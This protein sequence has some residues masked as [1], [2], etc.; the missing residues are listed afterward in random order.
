MTPL[1]AGLL[2]TDIKTDNISEWKLPEKTAETE[3]PNLNLAVYSS[4]QLV[5]ERPLP[6]PNGVL[7]KLDVVTE[8][9]ENNS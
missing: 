1:G 6:A 9:P 2:T 4:G 5:D 3:N 7:P 8:N